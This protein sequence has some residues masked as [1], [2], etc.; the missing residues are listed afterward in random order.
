VGKEYVGIDLHRRRSVIY[1]MDEQGEK[2][3]CVRI[4]NVPAIFAGEVSKAPKGSDVVLEATYGWYWAVDLLQELG[5][6]VPVEPLRQRLGPSTGEERRA[7]REGP[8]GPAPAG[9]FG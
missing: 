5:Y 2:I 7:R 8:R 6:E 1:R 3:D 4:D 9:A